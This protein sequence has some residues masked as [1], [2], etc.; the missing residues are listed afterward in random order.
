MNGL[1]LSLLRVLRAGGEGDEGGKDGAEEGQVSSSNGRAQVQEASAAP[2]R[3]LHCR[4]R[5]GDQGESGV[6]DQQVC[7]P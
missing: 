6:R 5:H 2:A 1:E 7:H 3:L 4:R